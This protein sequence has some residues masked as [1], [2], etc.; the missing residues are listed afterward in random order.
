M[1]PFAGHTLALSQF[2]GKSEDCL[3][4]L[5]V[6]CDVSREHRREKGNECWLLGEL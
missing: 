6:K 2:D 3:T 5:M 1:I 4:S